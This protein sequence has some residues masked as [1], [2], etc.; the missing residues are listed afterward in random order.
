VFRS[1]QRPRGAQADRP[2]VLLLSAQCPWPAAGGG[3][4][5][6]L[7]LIKR[8]SA[9]FDL[10]LVLVSQTVRED[11]QHAA[12][13]RAYC[14]Q[15]EVFPAAPR[16]THEHYA[17]DPEDSHLLAR[18]RS[19]RATGRVGE[20]L[21]RGEADLVHVDG[22]YLMQHVPEWVDVPVLLIE[23][24]MEYEIEPHRAS[25]FA[26][27]LRDLDAY[28]LFV[29]TRATRLG[30]WARATRLAAVTP[31]DRDMISA[32]LPGSEVGLIPDG[33]D[34]I[35]HLRALGASQRAERPEAPLITVMANFAC[36]TNVDA[37]IGFCQE[38]MPLIR[39]A[40]PNTQLML[41]GDTPPPEIEALE[42]DTVRVRRA[43]PDV[44]PY[45]DAADVVAC[46]LRIAGGSSVGATEALRR[47]KAVVATSIA[48]QELTG[49]A[50]EPLV[51][52]DGAEDFAGAVA[53]LLQDP[54]RR[55]DVERKATRAATRLPRW[56]EA[57]Q[58]LSAAYEDLLAQAPALPRTA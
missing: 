19:E 40:V 12:A 51:I 34:H 21:A 39:A 32:A 54:V 33:A 47:G 6:E 53:S 58:A 27:P 30:C 55:R 9:R 15:T 16:R 26:D 17:L 25:P 2:R 3:S 49:P 29:R 14:R 35:P 23:Q 43:V 13:L 48:A 44:V 22:F 56:D 57:A 5:R 38:T 28:R 24:N 1:S 7:E 36:A 4:R 31:K 45:L 50:R 18:H 10:H 42:S 41:V 46:P 11:L 20:I 52:A 8:I 37:A